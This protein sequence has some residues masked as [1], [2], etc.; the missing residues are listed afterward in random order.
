[1]VVSNQPQKGAYSLPERVLILCPTRNDSA[2]D[3]GTQVRCDNTIDSEGPSRSDFC[4]Y[5]ASVICG[6]H[7]VV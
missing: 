7:P 1:M 2:S 4:M 3:E 5:L 6:R